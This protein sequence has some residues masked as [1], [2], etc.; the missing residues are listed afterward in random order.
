MGLPPEHAHSHGHKT[1]VPW[2]D[3][4]LGLS[5]VSVSVMSLV[6]SIRHGNTM[7]EMVH[8][9]EKLVQAS[10]MPLLTAF[11]SENDPATNQPR[12]TLTVR[13][14]GIGP[15]VIDWF[16][17]SYKGTAYATM[18][19]LLHACCGTPEDGHTLRGVYYANITGTILPAKEASDY[20]TVTPAASHELMEAV[21]RARSDMTLEA[22]YCSVLDECWHTN[23]SLTRPKRVDRCEAPAGLEAW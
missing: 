6:V 11:G 15:A 7:E 12:L 1:G 22:C 14:G 19:A 2:L 8:Q 18:D 21:D 20:L 16:T 3:I 23:F 17:V 5:A 10:T 9:N 13:N 4:V